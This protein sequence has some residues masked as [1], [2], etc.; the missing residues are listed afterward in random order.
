LVAKLCNVLVP[1]GYL[2]IGH[3][4]SLTGHDVP[5]H[6]RAPAVYQRLAAKD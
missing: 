3:S 4:E 1:G 5:L 6:Q 2:F